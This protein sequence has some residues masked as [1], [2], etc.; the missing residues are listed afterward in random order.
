M[1]QITLDYPFVSK[2]RYPVEKP[3]RHLY[4]II[5]Q[6]REVYAKWLQEIRSLIPHFKQIPV[7][8]AN[9]PAQP[10]WENGWIP[11]LDSMA[12]YCFL[13][14]NNPNYYIEVGSGN[15][16]KFA[17]KAIS[18]HGLKTKIISIDPDPRAEIDALCD[19]VIRKRCEEVDLEVFSLLGEGDILFFDNSH[20]MFMNSDSTVSFLD[21]LP[22]LSPG[23]LVHFH[24]ICLPYD[25]PADWVNRYYSEQYG[26]ACYLLAQGP[27]LEIIL[28]CKFIIYD[29]PL[30]SILDE[31]WTGGPLRGIERNGCSFWLK[32]LGPQIQPVREAF[33]HDPAWDRDEWL[34]VILSYFET[35]R[36]GEP[37]ALILLLHGSDPHGH[38]LETVQQAILELATQ[39]GIE[40]FPDI[41]LVDQP[42]ELLETLRNYDHAQWVASG[43]SADAPLDGPMGARFNRALLQRGRA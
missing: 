7:T 15:S 36:Q 8:P 1:Y 9:T 30:I 14:K 18:D 43:P 11:P 13:A 31:I 17:R 33:I 28:P 21:I 12:L 22:M 2:P 16:T 6:N 42:E 41:V 3:N 40:A 29:Q 34:E 25:Y 19:Q 35:F 32:T 27:K 38:P 26:L 37:V 4:A 23:V 39:A 24:D 5:N 10:N 20:R